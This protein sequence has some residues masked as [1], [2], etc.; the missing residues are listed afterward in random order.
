MEKNKA[1]H[2]Y[3]NTGKSVLCPTAWHMNEVLFTQ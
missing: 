3:K 1:A 2:L